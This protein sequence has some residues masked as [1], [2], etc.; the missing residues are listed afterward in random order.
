MLAA[1]Q[2]VI[3]GKEPGEAEEGQFSEEARRKAERAQR[4]IG[5][6]MNL[7]VRHEDWTSEGIGEAIYTYAMW[8][9]KRNGDDSMGRKID[10][11]SLV[12]S[13]LDIPMGIKE[14]IGKQ[15]PSPNGGW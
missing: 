14:K 7:V 9:M 12:E 6:E 8:I 13:E 4:P 5:T 15:Y 2:G 11:M 3:I 10:R 1:D